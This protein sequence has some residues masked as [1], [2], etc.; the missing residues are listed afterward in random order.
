MGKSR[1]E[2][3]MTTGH[4]SKSMI[5]LTKSS[6]IS[7]DNFWNLVTVDKE[8]KVFLVDRN[9]VQNHFYK[10]QNEKKIPTRN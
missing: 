3:Y 1:N 2:F 10:Y 9:I 5:S 6:E 8:L 7:L 4:S